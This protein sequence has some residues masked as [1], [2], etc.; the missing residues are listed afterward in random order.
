MQSGFFSKGSEGLE[1]LEERW[2]RSLLKVCFENSPA[3]ARRVER[4]RI[5]PAFGCSLLRRRVPWLGVSSLT[6]TRTH[7]R[8][9]YPMPWSEAGFRRHDRPGVAGGPDRPWR[10]LRSSA[11]R[12]EETA[13]SR[14]SR[15]GSPWFGG[16]LAPP[17]SRIAR[18]ELGLQEFG[19]PFTWRACGPLLLG[20]S[21]FSPVP[22][23][24]RLRRDGWVEKR[25]ERRG[26]TCR[27]G[28]PHPVFGERLG[29]EKVLHRI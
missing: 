26:D 13:V 12:D 20:R 16:E 21:S 29:R 5:E 7:R 10:R 19:P 11:V 17:F 4:H 6:L 24:E 25:R 27:S 15:P 22:A 3:T 23:G 2:C 14:P 18:T 1:G 8:F 28:L 9:R